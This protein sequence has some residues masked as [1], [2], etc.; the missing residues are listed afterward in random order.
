MTLVSRKILPQFFIY[1]F[2]LNYCELQRYLL[3]SLRPTIFQHQ[4]YFYQHPQ[5]S[6]NISRFLPHLPTHIILYLPSPPLLSAFVAGEF[7]STIFLVY[8]SLIYAPLHPIGK[9]G[10]PVFHHFYCLWAFEVSF[11]STNFFISSILERLF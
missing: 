9:R 7:P 2:I 11:D 4:F 8:L 6:T 3:L 10:K 1:L 5:T